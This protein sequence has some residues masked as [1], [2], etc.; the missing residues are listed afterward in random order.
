MMSCEAGDSLRFLWK[1]TC[2]RCVYSLEEGNEIRRW[3]E[4]SYGA[5]LNSPRVLTFA[6]AT[7]QRLIEFGSCTKLPRG[8]CLVLAPEGLWVVS[9]LND[10]IYDGLKEICNDRL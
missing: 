8:W 7:G 4:N 3:K 6:K 5:C 2:G 1:V 9:C 10:D